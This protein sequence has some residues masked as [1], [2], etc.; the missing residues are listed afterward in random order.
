M[1]VCLYTIMCLLYVCVHVHCMHVHV[2]NMYYVH[3]LC[4]C[5]Y[6]GHHGAKLN[7]TNNLVL[8][9]KFNIREHLSM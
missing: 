1:C 3:V 9:S 6:F 5:M 2:L 7:C 4:T 8:I